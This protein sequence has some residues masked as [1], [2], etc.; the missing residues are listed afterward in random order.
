MCMYVCIYNVYMCVCV[1]VCVY[2]YL[3]TRYLIG[4][5]F[6]KL[7]KFTCLFMCLFMCLSVFVCFLFL[8]F[9]DLFFPLFSKWCSMHVIVHVYHVQDGAFLHM[10]C[11]ITIP[12]YAHVAVS[13]DGSCR[14]CIHKSR[15][16]YTYMYVQV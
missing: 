11:D 1:C 8:F 10:C 9:S 16:V 14:S 12:V 3:L 6:S 15:Y 13:R 2:I 7:M 4:I 5:Y